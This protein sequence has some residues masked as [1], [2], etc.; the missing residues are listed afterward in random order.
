MGF[1]GAQHGQRVSQCLGVR[2][3]ADLL[4]HRAGQSR[5]V[6]REEPLKA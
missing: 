2:V 6:Q 5:Q 1:E 4:C 3:K